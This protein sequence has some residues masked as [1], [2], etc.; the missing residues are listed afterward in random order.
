MAKRKDKKAAAELLAGVMRTAA[1]E[2]LTVADE[3]LCTSADLK[4]VL[5]PNGKRELPRMKKFRFQLLHEW[6]VENIEPCRVADVGG[7]KGLMAYLLGLS[8]WQATVIDPLPQ[9]LPAKYKDL[10]TGRQVSIDPSASV[11]RLDRAFVPEMA[12]DF[13]L[14]IALHAHG[15]NI[16]LID[17]AAA[18]Q[19]RLILL[20]CCIIDEPLIPTPGVHW[21]QCVADYAKTRGFTV[22]PFRVNFKGQNIG[23][24]L[25]ADLEVPSTGCSR[26]QLVFS[27]P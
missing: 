27:D 11:P 1:D 19:R 9:A 2:D 10:A 7:G 12:Q 20:P 15:C 26:N 4:R 6:I 16:M 3:A 5:E 8:G 14:L 24:Y 17:A 21:L 18:Y 25:M 13:D 23:L 22:K